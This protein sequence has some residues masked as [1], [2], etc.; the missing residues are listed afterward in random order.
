MLYEVAVAAGRDDAAESGR[1]PVVREF[2]AGVDGV[3]APHAGVVAMAERV[4]RAALDRTADAE[5][6]VD[7]DGALSLVLRLADGR[8]MLAELAVDGSLA[9]S[10]YDDDLGSNEKHLPNAAEADFTNHL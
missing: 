3:A 6:S 1:H 2:A 5:F 10:R 8:L 7:V 4:V 9:F